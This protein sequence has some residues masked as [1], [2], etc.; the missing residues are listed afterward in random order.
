[1]SRKNVSP[2]KPLQ[3]QP[4]QPA[5]PAATAARPGPAP[6]KAAIP[7]ARAVRPQEDEIRRRAYQKWEAAGRPGGDGVVFW[8]EAER[9][10][11]VAGR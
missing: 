8:L 3:A 11:Q 4:A 9:E 1:M 6:V 5:Q 7:V 10:L 2:L